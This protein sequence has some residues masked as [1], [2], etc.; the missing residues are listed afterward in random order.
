MY[1]TT[2]IPSYVEYTELDDYSP[3]ILLH[4]HEAMLTDTV[5]NALFDQWG[6]RYLADDSIDNFIEY[7]KEAGY[8]VPQIVGV[9]VHKFSD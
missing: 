4:E 2:F 9:G 1:A 7:L 8:K 3:Y 5:L 6:S